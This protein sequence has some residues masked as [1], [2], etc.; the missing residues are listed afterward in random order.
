MNGTNGINGNCG[1]PGKGGKN[2]PTYEGI[3]INEYVLPIFRKNIKVFD[4]STS[5]DLGK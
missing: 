5:G 4:E 2:G 1:I 3:Y